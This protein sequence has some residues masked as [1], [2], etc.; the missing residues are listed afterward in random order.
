MIAAFLP[1]KAIR[2]DYIQEI[3]HIPRYNALQK[4]WSTANFND[5]F[6]VIVESARLLTKEKKIPLGTTQTVRS[7]VKE[8]GLPSSWEPRIIDYDVPLPG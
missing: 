2:R 7:A 5:A 6:G 3:D 8:V 1:L 4:L